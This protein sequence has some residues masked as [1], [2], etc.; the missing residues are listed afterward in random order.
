MHYTPEPVQLGYILE[1]I[2]KCKNGTIAEQN[3]EVV[4]FMVPI[5][6]RCHSTKYRYSLGH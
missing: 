5:Q 3:I 6:F 4:R 1:W 2:Q